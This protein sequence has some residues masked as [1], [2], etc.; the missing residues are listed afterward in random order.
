MNHTFITPF[1][2]NAVFMIIGGMW[3]IALYEFHQPYLTGWGWGYWTFMIV[4]SLNYL[5]NVNRCVWSY[6]TVAIS[7]SM[8]FLYS[9][10]AIYTFISDFPYTVSIPMVLIAVG[11]ALFTKVI[12]VHEDIKKAIESE[13]SRIPHPKRL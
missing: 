13:A 1:Q 5:V 8:S 7:G 6:L 9:V 4:I 3:V 2:Y 12:Y 10:G 11:L